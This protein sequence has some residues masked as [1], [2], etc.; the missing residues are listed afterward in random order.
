MKSSTGKESYLGRILFI[1]ALAAFALYLVQD[2]KRYKL[3]TDLQGGTIL[4][5]KIRSDVERIGLD[6]DELTSALKRR[7]DPEGLKS[8][9]IR[10]LGGDEV[11]I[12]MP[13]S[14]ERDVDDVKRRISTVGQLKF[15]IVADRRKHAAEISLAERQWP[16]N[17]TAKRLLIG[18]DKTTVAEF[19]PYGKW[20]PAVEQEVIEQGKA[21]DWNKTPRQYKVS[22]SVRF[23]PVEMIGDYKPQEESNHLVREAEGKKWV[24][25]EYDDEGLFF[26]PNLNLTREDQFGQRFVLMFNDRYNVVGDYLTVASKGTKDQTGEPIVQ[27]NFN[28]TGGDLFGQLTGEYAAPRDAQ[29][30]DGGKFRLGIIFDGRLRSAPSLNSRITDS[31]LI[32]G[33]KEP[34]L[35]SIVKILNAGKLPVALEQQPEREFS[36]APTLGG[37]TIRS[38]A[39]SVIISLAVIGLFMV[40]YYRFAGFV[41]IIAL[42]FNILLTVALM[43]LIQQTWTLPGLAGLVLTVGMSV[44]ANVLVFERMR[45]E[46]DKGATVPTAIRLGYERAW[47]PILDSNITS[48]VTAIILYV[49]GTD[50]VRGFAVTLVCGIFTGLFTALTFTRL[51]FDFCYSRRIIRGFKFQRW[52]HNPNYDFLRWGKTAFV[53]SI[54]LIGLG[55]VAFGSRGSE[56][57]DI[58][59]TG[60]TMAGVKLNKELTTAQVRELAT[61]AGLKDVG[62]EQANPAR[63]EPGTSYFQIRSTMKEST[64]NPGAVKALFVKAFQPYLTAIQLNAGAAVPVP[65]LPK[66]EPGQPEPSIDPL[67]AAFQNGRQTTIKVEKPMAVDYLKHK[68]EDSIREISPEIGDP[69]TLVGVSPV[70]E[71]TPI[72]SAGREALGYTEFRVA[73]SRTDLDAIVKKTNDNFAAAPGFESFSSFGPQAARDMQL[74]AITAVFLSWAFIIFWVGYRFNNWAFGLGGVAALVHDVLMAVGLVALVSWVAVNVPAL[75]RFYVSDMKINLDMIAA[76]LTL[77]GYSIHDTIVTFDRVRELRGKGTRVTREMINRAV[78]ETLSR[79]IITS[80]LTFLAVFILFLGGGAALRGFAFLLVVGLIAG[81]YSTIFIANPVVLW[82]LNRNAQRDAVPP[83]STATKPVVPAKV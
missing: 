71:S 78:N 14:D 79:T 82:V 65:P 29:N 27:F 70:G 59:F 20:V 47:L 16:E 46:I 11:E 62:V 15:R 45:E 3:G 58:D 35:S 22:A 10:V 51:V 37:D 34:E 52:M 7:L 44:D 80:L 32:E 31:G 12:I 75:D 73:T 66:A 69:K 48:F 19:V 77:I 6:L 38:G 41:S 33:I 24:L 17:T 21:V 28:V 74:R 5:Y 30:D 50:Q 63:L 13:R 39:I 36:I 18:D 23:V 40:Y 76:I 54:I 25:A 53:A 72:F 68:L 49:I 64:E 2:P 42:A 26:S 83:P 8:Y 57:F 60:G 1:A 4:V 55:L 9:Q 81:T 56:N 67:T 61:D 43:N